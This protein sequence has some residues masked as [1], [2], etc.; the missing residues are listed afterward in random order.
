MQKH[1]MHNASSRRGAGG[2]LGCGGRRR[3]I[4]RIEM[5]FSSR[6]QQNASPRLLK[7]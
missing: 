3:I 1:N 7:S 5:E 2:G 4:K 6:N